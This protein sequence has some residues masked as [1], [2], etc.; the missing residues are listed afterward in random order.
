M[1]KDSAN[2]VFLQT[3]QELLEGREFPHPINDIVEFCLDVKILCVHFFRDP[4]LEDLVRAMSDGKF[5]LEIVES[6]CTHHDEC[7]SSETCEY[8]KKRLI[9]MLERLAEEY[10]SKI[11]KDKME[12][13]RKLKE[14]IK[15]IEQ[16]IL[17]TGSI[18]SDAGNSSKTIKD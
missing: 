2:Q 10:L 6:L 14:E 4:K 8:L 16:E 9:E 7:H 1:P 17:K 18:K 15:Q 13:Y 5:Q 11:V 3:I 12:K